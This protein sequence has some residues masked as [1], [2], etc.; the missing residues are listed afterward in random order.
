MPPKLLLKRGITLDNSIIT[1]QEIQHLQLSAN[2]RTDHRSLI[3]NHLLAL[4]EPLAL[5]HVVLY[6]VPTESRVRPN[7]GK[8]SYTGRHKGT[9]TRKENVTHPSSHSNRGTHTQ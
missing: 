5:E 3:T 9:E 8:H 6:K 4:G 7:T 1:S 2:A